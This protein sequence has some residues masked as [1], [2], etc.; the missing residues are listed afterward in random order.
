VPQLIAAALIAKSPEKYGLQIQ[1]QP[2]YAY[3]SVKVGP[4]TPLAAVAK[5][6]GARAVEIAE[7]NPMILRGVTPPSG[8][9]WVR[10]PVGRAES[11]D[12][13][14]AALSPDDRRAFTKVVTKKNETM[15][16][17]ANRSGRTVRQ[18]SWYNPK[19][20]KNKR[21]RL[22][23]GQTI[24]V[25]TAAVTAAAQDVPDPSIERYGSPARGR[26]VVH[27]V[28]RGETLNGIARRYHT[29]PARIRALNHLRRNT[30]FPGQE[31]IVKAPASRARKAT[32]RGRSAASSPRYA[33]TAGRTSSRA[34]SAKVASKKGDASSSKRAAVKGPTAKGKRR[35]HR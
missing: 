28:R 7:L 16:S 34:A 3:D 20:E 13:S 30:I 4:A 15:A 35:K 22:Y 21:G 19:V 25:P 14:F 31:L 32:R 6:S 33:A 23:P 24:L 10:V 12:S 26:L 2:A 17:I 18:L 27:V 8:A 1:P 11:F 29:E 5:A 9:F